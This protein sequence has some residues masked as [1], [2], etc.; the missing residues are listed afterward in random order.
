MPTEDQMR[1]WE[2]FA[3][4]EKFGHIYNAL[5]DYLVLDSKYQEWIHARSDD[6]A[7]I[8]SASTFANVSE[9]SDDSLCESGPTP[10]ERC[11][12]VST[13]TGTVLVIYSLSQTL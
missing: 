13:G 4:L 8:A 5:M 7:S 1:K 3:Y 11:N 2:L 12:S 9:T 6:T 10:M